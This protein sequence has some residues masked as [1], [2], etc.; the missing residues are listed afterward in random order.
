MFEVDAKLVAQFFPEGFDP[1]AI[2]RVYEFG[3]SDKSGCH[4]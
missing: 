1:P 2:W 4:K 3:L